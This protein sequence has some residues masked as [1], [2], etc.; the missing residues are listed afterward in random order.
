M[1]QHLILKSLP[2]HTEC[3]Q[4]KESHDRVSQ[5]TDTGHDKSHNLAE[6]SEVP[7]M[8]QCADEVHAEHDL[9]T[10]QDCVAGSPSRPRC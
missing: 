1:V 9:L 2:K 8:S 3:L 10:F 5:R 7:V 6:G 4:W